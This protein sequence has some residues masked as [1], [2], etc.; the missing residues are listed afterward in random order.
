[1][2]EVLNWLIIHKIEEEAENNWVQV[3]KNILSYDVKK[4]KQVISRS[5]EKAI[6]LGK[7]KIVSNVVISTLY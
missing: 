5:S 2:V 4:S 1:M 3:K 6:Y 7:W